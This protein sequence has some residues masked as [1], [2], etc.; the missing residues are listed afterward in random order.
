VSVTTPP[1]TISLASDSAPL[2]VTLN[3]DLPVLVNVQLKFVN[4][5]G[6]RPSNVPAEKVPAYSSHNR[7]IPTQVI[8]SGRFAVDVGLQTPDGGTPLGRLERIQLQSTHYGPVPLIVTIAAGAALLLL[9][10]RRLV[11]RLRDEG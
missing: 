7:A 1:Q 3:N 5:V 2:P 6:L 8:R 11:R 9:G 10:T 4:S